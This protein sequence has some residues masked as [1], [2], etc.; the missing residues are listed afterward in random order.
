VYIKFAASDFTSES[1]T[2]KITIAQNTFEAHKISL[3]HENVRGTLRFKNRVPWPNTWYSPGIMGP[4]AFVPFMECYHGILSMNHEIE[5]SLYLNGETID[6]TGGRGYMEKD[7]GHSFPSAYCWM[8]SNHF[9]QAG[10][11]FKASVAKIPWLNSSFVGFI[12][13]LYFNQQL[14]Q[15]T[16]YNGTKLLRSFADKQRVELHMENRN[17]RLEILAHRSGATQL[18]APIA[19]FMDGRISESMTSK[20]ELKLVA[21]SSGKLLFNDTGRNTGLEVAGNIKEIIILNK[22][23]GFERL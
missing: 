5:G 6:F 13:G 7:W 22:S 8:Q 2:F 10:I 19:G 4:Y 1:D 11:S 3:Q 9:S 12:A 21:K 14:L 20:I 23:S 16:T 18:A 15:F 17:Y